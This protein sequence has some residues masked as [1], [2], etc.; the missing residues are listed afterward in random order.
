M[1]FEYNHYY[2]IYNPGSGMYV[3]LYGNHDDGVVS[4]GEKVTMYSRLQ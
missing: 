4:N 3:N 2:D 1:D